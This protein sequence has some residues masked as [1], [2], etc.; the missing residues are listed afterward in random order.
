MSSKLRSKIEQNANLA[1]CSVAIDI[2]RCR[3]NHVQNRR[4]FVFLTSVWVH[5]HMETSSTPRSEIN[6]FSHFCHRCGAFHI[7]RRRPCGFVIL[8]YYLRKPRSMPNPFTSPRS[9]GHLVLKKFKFSAGS[10]SVGE[11]IDD[12]GSLN[13]IG[14][15]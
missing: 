14:D 12:Y 1:V 8:L 15:S 11:D 5:S 4:F 6:D 13:T 10:V 3:Q 2:W 7:S 9:G